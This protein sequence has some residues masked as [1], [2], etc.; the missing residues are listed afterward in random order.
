MAVDEHRGTGH[1]ARLV[2]N[3]Q[4]AVA[5][6][7]HLEHLYAQFTATLLSLLVAQQHGLASREVTEAPPSFAGFGC[8]LQPD[9]LGAGALRL[10]RKGRREAGQNS[11]TGH[12]QSL[13]YGE[14]MRHIRHRR[15]A[16]DTVS[17]L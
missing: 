9:F 2:E 13:R 10:C 14:R 5:V 8:N 17:G 3:E 1:I 6:A 11:K 4:A 7:F 16:S 12:K 15:M